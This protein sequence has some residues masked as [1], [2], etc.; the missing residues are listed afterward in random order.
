[1]R[2]G[3]TGIINDDLI[4]RT[5]L[6]CVVSFSILSAG[7]GAVLSLLFDLVMMSSSTKSMEQNLA[8]WAVIGLVVGASCGFMLT[9]KYETL[10]LFFI[11]T[12][13]MLFYVL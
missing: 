13:L 4:S 8:L 9:N 5:M 2:R 10:S 7:L 11:M 1:M 3:W 12:S 6:L